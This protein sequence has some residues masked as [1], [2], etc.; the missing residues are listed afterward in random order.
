MDNKELE[1]SNHLLEND[2]EDDAYEAGES[3]S[4]DEIIDSFINGNKSWVKE[5]IGD[6]IGK[7]ASVIQ[8]VIDEQIADENFIRQFVSLFV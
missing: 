6:D 5:Q 7:L 3:A 2:Y 4:I 1:K 8:Y